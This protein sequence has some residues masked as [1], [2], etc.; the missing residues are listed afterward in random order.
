M[1]ENTALQKGILEDRNSIRS[2]RCARRMT[3]A[4]QLFSIVSIALVLA[5]VVALLAPSLAHAAP[6]DLP[7]S[8][9]EASLTIHKYVLPDSVSPGG[10]AN[11]ST[12]ASASIPKDAQPLQGITF[13]IRRI[14]SAQKVEMLVSYNF[15]QKDEFV[16]YQGNAA[17]PGAFFF[18][19][20]DVASE[21]TT[22][23]QGSASF[24]LTGAQG[25]YLVTEKPDPRVE[26][27]CDPFIVSVPM[28]NP[29]DASSWLYDVHV[30]P[31]NYQID[32]DKKILLADGSLAMHDGASR[33]DPV[34]FFL[35]C[36][37]PSDVGNCQSFTMTDELDWRL[38]AAESAPENLSVTAAGKELA[39][40]DDF[41]VNVSESKDSAD[42]T[43]QTVTI[44]FIPGKEKLQSIVNSC[45]GAGAS[46]IAVSFSARVNSNATFGK[47]DNQAVFDITNSVGTHHSHPTPKPDV[48]FGE[49]E[50]SKLSATDNAEKLPGAV[51]RIAASKEDAYKGTWIHAIDSAGKDLGPWEVTTDAS[52]KAAFSG[53]SYDLESGTDYYLVE[54]QAPEGY[55]R[56]TEPIVAH[57]GPSSENEGTDASQQVSVRS[58]RVL[59]TPTTSLPRTGGFTDFRPLAAGLV[60]V[61]CSLLTASIALVRARRHEKR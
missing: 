47:F 15:A 35:T 11:G 27:P 12:S 29:D 13:S 32:V 30:Y 10:E 4:L 20:Q 52:G 6:A 37:I 58:I 23:D 44:D 3:L 34:T 8:S 60:A 55:Q 16:A 14:Y 51:F 59:N 33:G 7:D 28:E 38:T 43:R 54:V 46:K 36:D 5:I 22:N 1:H 2:I 61:G 17:K 50:I 49:I 42:R 41:T 24:S 57:L 31:K 19:K 21:Q 18:N 26:V 48:S 39:L 40:N 53:L 56:L 9:R 25:Y 45:N